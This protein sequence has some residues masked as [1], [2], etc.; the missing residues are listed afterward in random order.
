MPIFTRLV[1][2]SYQNEDRERSVLPTRSD[3]FNK[4]TVEREKQDKAKQ[5]NSTYRHYSTQKNRD[6]QNQE[7]Y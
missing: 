6:E 4:K 1:A 3:Q 2:I 7:N 5:V